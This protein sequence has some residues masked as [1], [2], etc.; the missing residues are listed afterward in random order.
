[1]GL[2]LNRAG[3]RLVAAAAL[4]AAAVAIAIAIIVGLV[5]WVGSCQGKSKKDDYSSYAEKVSAIATADKKL[6][7]DFAS[8]LLAATKPSELET[9]L[10][11]FAQQEQQAYVQAQ[12][13]RPPG[14]LRTIHQNVVD[15]IELRVKGLAG[16]GDALAAPDALKK[17]TETVTSLMKQGQVLTASDVVWEQLYRMPATQRLVEQNVKGV[18]IPAS[19]FVSNADIVSSRSFTLLLDRLGGA[20]TG[21]TPSGKHGDGVVSVRVTPQGSDLS[22]D[23]ATTVQ[24]TPELTFVATI[25]NSGDFQEVNVPVTLTIDFGGTPIKSQKRIDL[26]TPGE[27]KTVSFTGFD[28]PPAAFGA[29]STTVTVLVSPVK[30]EVNTSNNKVTY[31]VFFTLP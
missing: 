20:S 21:G 26:I 19:Q 8:S 7:E 12:Q 28:L 25:E 23:T 6:G 29:Q 22:T 17:K 16:L 30:G 24:V 3:V 15:A 9:T 11:Q 18:A 2:A 13:I 4:V 5:F 1:V 14:P 31:S 10:Q 27:R